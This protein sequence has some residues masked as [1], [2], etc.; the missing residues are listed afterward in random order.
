MK[1]KFD[2]TDRVAFTENLEN[3]NENE[4]ESKV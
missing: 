3:E 4:T 1:T 2:S